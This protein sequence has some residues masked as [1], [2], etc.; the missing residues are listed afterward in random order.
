MMKLFSFFVLA[1]MCVVA[2]GLSSII[3]VC[4]EGEKSCHGAG[5]TG[6]DGGVFKY[7]NCMS[8]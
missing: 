8:Q 7:T 4:K 2:V 3:P 5:H 6:K 1:L